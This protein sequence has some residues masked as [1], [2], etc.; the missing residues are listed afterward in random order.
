MMSDH[1]SDGCSAP[2]ENGGGLV[3]VD[4]TSGAGGLTVDPAQFDAYY[5]APQKCFGSDGGLWV[6]LLSPAALDRIARIGALGRWVPASMDLTIAVDNSKLDQT[7]NTP[8]L[9][10]LF[11]LDNQIQWFNDNGGL[12]FATGRSARSAEILYTWA[13]S[14]DFATPV[15]AAG[16]GPQP[17]DRDHRPDRRHRRGRRW[18]PSCGPTGSWTPSPTGSWAATSSGSPCSRLWTRTTWRRCARASTTW[19]GRWP[20]RQRG[21]ARGSGTTVPEEPTLLGAG[22]QTRLLSGCRR[23]SWPSKSGVSRRRYPGSSACRR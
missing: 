3:A 12:A 2:P 10:T 7:Y 14:S 9:A 4:A 17:R 20:G 1:P 8:A 22:S 13:D 21:G 18:P 5:F 16:G 19:W 23:Q 15:R 11:L 6:A